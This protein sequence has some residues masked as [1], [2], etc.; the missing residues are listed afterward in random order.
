MYNAS[1][2]IGRCLES[3]LEQGIDS[4][5][6]EIIVVNDGSNDGSLA[7]VEEFQK[8]YSNIKIVS[9]ENQGQSV[10]RNRGIREATGKYLWFIDADDFLIPNSLKGIYDTVFGDGKK[11]KDNPKYEDIDIITFDVIRGPEKE[12]M[13]SP[14]VQSD[15]IYA[16]ILNGSD[17]IATFPKRFPN[18]PWWYFIRKKFVEASSLYFH[19]GKLLEDG[20]F[21]I[22]ALLTASSVGHISQSLYYYALRPGSTMYTYTLEQLE[23]INDGFRNAISYLTKLLEEHKTEMGP[24]CYDRLIAR[25]NGYIVFLLV[26]LL[27]YG[28]TSHAKEALKWLKNEHLYP[29]GPLIGKDYKNWR[30]RLLNKFIN[31]ERLYLFS[32]R[33]YGGIKS[34]Q[35]K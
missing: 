35:N 33:V 15:P 18:G 16:P 7:I 6:Y 17:F 22:T 27:K 34:R 12:F 13:P 9:Q 24:E 10:A 20:L 5:G 2:F 30:M 21:I 32:C 14:T 29:I 26:R 3:I 19:E 31:R 1:S 4:N 8:T 11:N 28:T 25:R 23:K